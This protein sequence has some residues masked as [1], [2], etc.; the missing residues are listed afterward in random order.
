VALGDHLRAHQHVD[1]AGM[2]RAELRFQRALRRVLSASMRA[3]RG[4][5]GAQPRQ[6]L[7]EPLGAAA[8]RRD[9][10]VAAV[11]AGARH[12]LAEAAVVAAQRAVDLWNTRQALQCGQPLFQ[13]QSPHAAPAR[14]RAGSGTPGSARRARCALQRRHSGGDSAVRA[15]S[16]AA[17]FMSTS[18]TAGSAPPPMRAGSASR[19]SGP[20]PRPARCQLF[21]RRR[22]RAEQHRRPLEPA[23]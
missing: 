13:P 9:V 17:A 3:M 18:R 22:R 16:S 11:R 4:R 5:L 20:P 2:H 7:L 8:D 21:E 6:L 14:S 19:G 23:A 1:V 12:A 15:R 10:G